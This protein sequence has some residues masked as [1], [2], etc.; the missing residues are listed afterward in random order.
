MRILLLSLCLLAS[1]AWL[2]ASW[3]FSFKLTQSGPCYGDVTSSY[4]FPPLSGLPSKDVCESFRSMVLAARACAAVYATSPPYQY[5]GDCCVFYTCT[6]CTGFDIPKALSGSP[7]GDLNSTGAAAG[8]PMFSPNPNTANNNWDKEVQDK[9]AQLGQGARPFLGG[10]A[11]RE[12]GQGPRIQGPRTGNRAFDNGYHRQLQ[13]YYAPS[14]IGPQ[15]TVGPGDERTTEDEPTGPIHWAG[16]DEA[17]QAQPIGGVGVTQ[18]EPDKA[19]PPSPESPLRHS[20]S[21][22]C[23]SKWYYNTRTKMCYGPLESCQYHGGSCIQSP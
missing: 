6:P 14:R 10:G 8:Q 17:A 23:R 20:N 13:R 2:K 11:G 7:G 1:P 22:E 3:S 5:I 12:R 19:P 9:L 15:Y 16:E 18:G 4:T 21:G